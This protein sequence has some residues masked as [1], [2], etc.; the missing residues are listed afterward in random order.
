MKSPFRF[1]T[2]NLK[3]DD[4]SHRVL[5]HCDLRKGRGMKDQESHCE[6]KRHPFQIR[7]ETRPNFQKGKKK[8]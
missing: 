1:E 7:H 8:E 5:K 6:K 2:R 3:A 4:E